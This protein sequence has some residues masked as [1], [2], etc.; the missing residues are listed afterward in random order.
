MSAT[1]ALFWSLGRVGAAPPT[2]ALLLVLRG[3]ADDSQVRNALLQL[4]ERVPRMRQR[5]MP[6]PLD[7]AP[8]EWVADDSFAL[9]NHIRPRRIADAADRKTLLAAARRCLAT[10]LRDDRPLWA[11]FPFVA[12]DARC[13]AVLLGFHP[14][15]TEGAGLSRLLAGLESA[16]NDANPS[17]ARFSRTPRLVSADAL[18][19]RA[20]Q[21]N[22]EELTESIESARTGVRDALAAPVASGLRLW[23]LAASAAATVVDLV[24][25]GVS[26][27]VRDARHRSRRLLTGELDFRELDAVCARLDCTAEALVT[28]LIAAGLDAARGAAGQP[29]LALDVVVPLSTGADGRRA[30]VATTLPAAPAPL[31]MRLHQTADALD[32]IGAEPSLRLYALT[33]RFSQAVPAP[34]IRTFG[35]EFSRGADVAHLTQPGPTKAIR[36]A[37]QLVDAIYPFAPIIGVPPVV[38]ATHLFRRKLFVGLDIDPHAAP[39][40]EGIL[41]AI[42]AAWAELRASVAARTGSPSSPH[43][44]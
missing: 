31:A 24:N 25:P 17:A 15:M 27:N 39:R 16:P 3:A 6:V 5:V 42:E 26:A 37:G 41:A 36:F 40:P 23:R 29:A 11:A 22:A 32:A 44:G 35:R 21:F 10:P 28:T 19:W 20:L 38:V 8:P 43:R 2:V 14:C 1:D 7:A 34:I 30:I 13:R 4:C 18:L 33:A 12:N 9:A